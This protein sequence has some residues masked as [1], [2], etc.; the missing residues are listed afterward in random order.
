[1]A[2][3]PELSSSGSATLR[4]MAWFKKEP[5]TKTLE[6]LIESTA[7]HAA[8]I[9]NGAICTACKDDSKCSIC[10]FNPTK[11]ATQHGRVKEVM[12]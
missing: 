10:A 12:E 2:Y 9:S 4:R 5:M 7:R 1:M 11:T 8:Q 3:T 6:R